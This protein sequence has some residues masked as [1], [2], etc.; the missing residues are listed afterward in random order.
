MDLTAL[1]VNN[2]RSDHAL[3]RMNE[4]K[5]HMA[6]TCF[7]WVGGVDGNAV[8]YYRIQSPV[9]L[10]EFDHELPGAPWPGAAVRRADAQPYP[11]HNEDP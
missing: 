7:G 2:I 6:E 11:R 5:A 1:W 10:I 9:I 8:F 3:I 4:V